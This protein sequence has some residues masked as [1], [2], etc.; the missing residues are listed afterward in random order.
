MTQI[1]KMKTQEDSF[2]TKTENKRLKHI[3][4]HTK[5]EKKLVQTKKV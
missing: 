2:N 5:T 3:H 1:E 4:F